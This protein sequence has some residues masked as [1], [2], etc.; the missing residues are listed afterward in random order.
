MTKK[1]CKTIIIVIAV[2]TALLAIVSAVS[3]SYAKWVPEESPVNC[4]VSVYIPKST[5]LTPE[6]IKEITDKLQGGSGIFETKPSGVVLDG[7][8]TD[9]TDPD[10]NTRDE[11]I[12]GFDKT[13]EITLVKDQSFYLCADGTIITADE[14]AR[15]GWT[16]N[17]NSSLILEGTQF[18]ATEDGVYLIE[19]KRGKALAIFT[20]EKTIT[21][22]KKQ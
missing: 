15:D 11:I 21:I 10:T 6:E 19:I 9:A 17:N 1:P 18:T 22:T 8:G 16:L 7:V 5:S 4:S 13:C 12:W 14:S 2:L 3:V 20:Y